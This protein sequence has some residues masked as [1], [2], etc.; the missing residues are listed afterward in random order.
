MMNADINASST[1]AVTFFKDFAAKT[2]REEVLTLRALGDLIATTT[3]VEKT[4]LPWL[5][6]A[7]FGDQK[8]AHLSLR[9]NANVTEITGIC[10]DYDG[11]RVA[12]DAACQALLQAG[13]AAIVYTSPS[14]TDAAPRWR[15]LAPLSRAHPPQLPRQVHGAAQWGGGRH[16]FARKLDPVAELLFRQRQQ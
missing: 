10:G 3:A 12:F 5:K 13:V 15:V 16:P 11:E 9:H 7:R 2:K 14:H 8:T 1:V 4:A 6:L